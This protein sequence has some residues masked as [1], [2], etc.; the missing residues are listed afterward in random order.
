MT[1][2]I[3]LF[4]INDRLA[5]FTVKR[6]KTRFTIYTIDSSITHI[7]H[8]LTE[9]ERFTSTFYLVDNVRVT[10]SCL[11]RCSITSTTS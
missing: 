3:Q 2:Y 5:I 1:V 8:V 6:F 10:L 7:D 4:R 11:P 9:A